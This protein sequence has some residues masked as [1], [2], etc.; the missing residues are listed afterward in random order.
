MVWWN[1]VPRGFPQEMVAATARA[2]F[3]KFGA[4]DAEALLEPQEPLS[5][6]KPGAGEFQQENWGVFANSMKYLY[7]TEF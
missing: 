4:W 3:A 6:T 7:P 1:A 2:L 5:G